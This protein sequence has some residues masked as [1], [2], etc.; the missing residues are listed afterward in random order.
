VR[1]D[2]DCPFRPIAGSQGQARIRARTRLRFVE[3]DADVLGLFTNITSGAAA[4]LIA[5]V[6]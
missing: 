5:R 3:L 6:C 2:H 4:L 1:R